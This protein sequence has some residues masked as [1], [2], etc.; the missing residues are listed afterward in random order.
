MLKTL[1]ELCLLRTSPS[2]LPYSRAVLYS[3]IVLY[4]GI[5]VLN[6]NQVFESAYAIK[7]FAST[8]ATGILM[9]LIYLLL[10]KQKK[11]IR[12]H[13]VLMAWFGTDLILELLGFALPDYA[14]IAIALLLWDVFIKANILKSALEITT[15]RAL[16]ITVALIFIH[17]LSLVELFWLFMPSA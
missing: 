2:N 6:F 12:T 4:V 3:F 15:N 16:I 11:A 5:C 14:I 9:M 7:I 8:F 13:K 1:A 17:T 10:D